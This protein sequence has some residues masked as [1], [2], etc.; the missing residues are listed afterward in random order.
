EAAEEYY[1]RAL[2]AEPE[3]A[4]NLGSYAI[5]L[6]QVRKD[7]EAAEEYYKR[8]LAA[9]PENANNLGS[10]ANFLT[11]TRK[12][13]EAAEEYYQR[14][15]AAGSD[16]VDVLGFYA[17]FLWQVHKDD[18]AA[19][20]YFKRALAADPTDFNATANYTNF[21]LLAKGREEGLVQLGALLRRPEARESSE[22][23]LEAWFYAW[24]HEND[25]VRPRALSMLK[26]LLVDGVRSRDWNLS[27]H[28]HVAGE[29]GWTEK[30]IA[31]INDDAPLSSLAGWSDWND[32]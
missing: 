11:I 15:L 1:K 17:N 7:H 10:Y 27:G 20:E 18:E 19:E 12:D 9:E 13:H 24:V 14:A 30:L 3:N 29:R 22:P 8:A 21:L 16:N 5:F 28:V 25:E 31:V 4:A 23:A 2:A 6:K 32:A 26:D